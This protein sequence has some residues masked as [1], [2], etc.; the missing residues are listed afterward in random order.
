MAAREQA[1]ASRL[2]RGEI[3]RLG[4]EREIG[5]RREL[6]LRRRQIV[7][8]N[9]IAREI[10]IRPAGVLRGN[11]GQRVRFVKGFHHGEALAPSAAG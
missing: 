4:V 3:N 1:D 2:R 7:Q 9:R 8:E 5:G 11:G 10:E 6:P